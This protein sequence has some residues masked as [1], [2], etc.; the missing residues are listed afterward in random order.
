[1]MV[2][3]IVDL[4]TLM[5]N[6][7]P[8]DS[9][10]I[11]LAQLPVLAAHVMKKLIPEKQAELVKKFCDVFIHGDTQTV[12]NIDV[13]FKPF[14]ISSPLDHRYAVHRTDFDF[15][16]CM[17]RIFAAVIGSMN[18]S[19]NPPEPSKI[20]QLLVQ[21]VVMQ[22][23]DA[24]SK[25]FICQALSAFINKLRDEESLTTFIQEEVWTNQDLSHS[26]V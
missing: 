5:L 12:L 2:S 20:F 21:S 4:M 24:D 17:T 13:Q 14:F 7:P 6:K 19:V 15:C 9:Q 8:A 3:I 25:Q 16:R 10:K 22:G 1:M 26:Q 18:K 23:L 11:F